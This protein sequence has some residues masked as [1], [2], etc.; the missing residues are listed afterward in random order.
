MSTI[1]PSSSS[2]TLPLAPPSAG[3]AADSRS[4]DGLRHA[5][6]RDPKAAVHQAAKQFETVFMQEVL[7]SMR[8]ASI[9][10]GMLDN[11]GSD[12][13]SEM[14]DTQWASQLSGRPGG[15]ADLIARQLSRNLGEAAPQQTTAALPPR[16]RELPR[17][18]AA[19][20]APGAQGDFLRQHWSAAKVAEQETG[21][22]AQFVLA[23][24]AHESGWGRR[25]IR[26]ADGSTSHNVFGIKAGSSWSGRVAEVTTTE[27]IGG[28]PRR[29]VQ[30]FRAYDSYEDA[31]RDYARLLKGNQRYAQVMREGTSV[32]GFTRGLQKAGY[33]TDPAYADKLARVIDTTLRLQRSSPTA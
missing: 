21:I 1:L 12:L 27:Y 24:A 4:L 5:A 23:Q 22:P 10:S 28:Q 13:G 8:A 9:K 19:P 20:R 18:I 7:K 6:G 2:L 14:L 3:L 33:A 29:M 32:E 31:Y 30:K 16:F 11:A 17:D 15:L 25:E 26:N